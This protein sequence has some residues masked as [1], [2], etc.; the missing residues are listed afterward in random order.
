[1]QFFS[2]SD[3]DSSLTNLQQCLSSLRSSFFHNGL[4]LNSD[5]TEVISLVTT[6]RRQSIDTITSIQVSDASVTLS[7]YIQLLGITLDN[8]LRFDKHV[9]NV[10]WIS[11]FHK[12]ALRPIRTC[13]DLESSEYIACAT[14]S[15]GLTMRTRAYLQSLPTTSID[16]SEFKTASP[17]SFNPITLLFRHA[18]NLLPFTDFQFLNETCVKLEINKNKQDYRTPE[19]PQSQ[20]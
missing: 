5:K 20:T 10:C 1:M 3:L 4:A 14:V 17:A 6:H 15:S 11:Y 16:Y 13:L 8:R 9:S 18:R 12:R 2:A 7:Y 19:L